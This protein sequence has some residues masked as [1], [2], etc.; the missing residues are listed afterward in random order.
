MNKAFLLTIC[1]LLTSFTG[2]I[3]TEDSD[4][5]T[6]DNIEEIIDET[7]NTADETNNTADETNNTVDETNNTNDNDPSYFQPENRDELKTAVDEWIANSTDA[8]STYGHIKTWDTSLVTDMS[9][10]FY[11]KYSF[12]DDI[13]N[14][15]VSSVYDMRGMFQASSF[16]QDIGSWDVSS[17]T[18]M[19]F[20]FAYTIGFN[21]D[22]SD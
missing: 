10:L 2:C 1:L 19:S 7:N 6:I 11:H 20:M 14:W 18:D 8:N 5:E 15:D 9:E 13:S 12:N 17:V 21:Q 3:E 22:I 4:L 16:N